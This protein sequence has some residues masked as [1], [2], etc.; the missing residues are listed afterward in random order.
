[1]LLQRAHTT[2]LGLI[3]VCCAVALTGCLGG[4]TTAPD[5]AGESANR[6]AQANPGTEPDG[7]LDAATVA[8][9]PEEAMERYVAA[10]NE[11]DTRQLVRLLGHRFVFNTGNKEGIPE[12]WSRGETIGAAREIFDGDNVMNVSLSMDWLEPEPAGDLAHPDWLEVPV[13]SVQLTVE[14]LDDF[15]NILVFQV[16]GD[17]ARF[18]LGRRPSF[19]RRGGGWQIMSQWDL[20]EG[21]REARSVIIPVTWSRLLAQFM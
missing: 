9:S 1:M 16:D 7:G 18:I 15:N 11:R 20:N 17:P 5:P 19:D 8:N 4:S 21:E 14:I 13:T 10:W 3:G 12:T 2:T 6:E